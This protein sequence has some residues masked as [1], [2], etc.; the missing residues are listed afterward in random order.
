MQDGR[1]QIH[2]DH[3]DIMIA[4]K[5]V[6]KTHIHLKTMTI[7]AKR[8]LETVDN[9]KTYDN[10]VNAITFNVLLHFLLI[11]TRSV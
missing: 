11:Q 7:A 9:D 4:V 1:A 2:G 3:G 6:C 5:R 8:I 10:E